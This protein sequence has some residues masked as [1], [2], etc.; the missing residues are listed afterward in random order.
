MGQGNLLQK[1]AIGDIGGG[2]DGIFRGL[3]AVGQ[4]HILETPEIPDR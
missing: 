4:K 2:T 1:A 3:C